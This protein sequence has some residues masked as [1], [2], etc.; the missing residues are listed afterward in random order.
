MSSTFE[1][2]RQYFNESNVRWRV[3]IEGAIEVA[4]EI[5]VDEKQL[6][7][8]AK[9][10][11]WMTNDA[12][13]GIGLNMEERF[14]ETE[15]QKLWAQAFHT[16]AQRVYRRQWGNQDNQTWQVHFITSCHLVSL[17][18]TSLVWKVDRTWYPTPSD[19]EGIRPD[20]MRIQF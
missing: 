19:P 7:W 16:L 2:G 17:F 11:H 15:E 12:W 14:S 20:P 6:A 10:E 13:P 18:L 1:C 4:K 5:A 9:L 3:M 8:I